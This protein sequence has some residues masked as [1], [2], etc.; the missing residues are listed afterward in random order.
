MPGMIYNNSEFLCD[1]C[2]KIAPPEGKNCRNHCPHCLYSKHV[3]GDTPGDRLGYCQGLMPATE[4]HKTSKGEFL[5]H[6]CLKCTHKRKNRVSDDDNW[7]AIIALS[8]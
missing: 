1:N 7:D 4:Y 6:E 2:Q 5:L 8:F 3:D